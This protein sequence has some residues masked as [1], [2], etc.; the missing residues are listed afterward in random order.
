MNRHTFLLAILLL[1]VS[2][3]TQSLDYE[4]ARKEYRDPQPGN[5]LNRAV[6]AK[7][8]NMFAKRFIAGASDVIPSSGVSGC[9]SNCH[10]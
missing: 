3:G 1:A 2:A 7:F 9:W 6:I 4:A 8:T 10:A 5:L